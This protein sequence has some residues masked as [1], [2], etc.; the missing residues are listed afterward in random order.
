MRIKQSNVKIQSC[1]STQLTPA[2]CAAA[3]WLLGSIRRFRARLLPDR[4]EPRSEWTG[5]GPPL[6]THGPEPGLIRGSYRDP[7]G[8]AA[9]GQGGW[10]WGLTA[11][12]TRGR[13][14]L[15]SR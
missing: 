4:P 10:F 9:G 15:H 14:G 5:G 7:A 13:L 1:T 2:S 11:P 6:T 12:W 8:L 3:T